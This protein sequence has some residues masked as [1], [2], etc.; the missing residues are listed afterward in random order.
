MGALQIAERQAETRYAIHELIGRRWSPRAFSPRPVEREKL[1]SL[2]E[3]AR[4][5]PSSY[6]DQPWSYI[7]A[8]KGDPA[9]FE[10]MLDA[11]G[12]FNRQWAKEAPVLVLAVAKLHFE[13]SGKP[14]R[15]AWYDVGQAVANLTVQA[16]A[17]DLYVHQMAGF[18]PARARELFDIPDGHE[19]VA[20]MAAGYLG[21][22]ATLPEP[23]RGLELTP[24]TRKPLEDFVFS[25]R[26]GEPSPLVADDHESRRRG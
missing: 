13:R 16:T 20:V 22:P 4:W 25:G 21:D 17:L 10:R 24:S 26:W 7:V 6:N 19:P 2:L 23:L 8:T 11:L 15:H 14:N 1:Q 18:D 12:D 5:A 3:A 9:N